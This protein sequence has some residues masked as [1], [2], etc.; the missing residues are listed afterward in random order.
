M[1]CSLCIARYLDRFSTALPI[2]HSLIRMITS[3]PSCIHI[4]CMLTYA[5]SRSRPPVH[6]AVYSAFRRRKRL[7]GRLV[8]QPVFPENTSVIGELSVEQNPA[9]TSLSTEIVESSRPVLEIAPWRLHKTAAASSP[10]RMAATA[11]CRAGNST[12]ATACPTPVRSS[13]FSP[14]MKSAKNWPLYPGNSIPLATS[15]TSW[16]NSSPRWRKIAFRAATPFP[17]P[18]SPNSCCTAF[19]PFAARSRTA[20]AMRA[21][22]KLCPLF[23]PTVQGPL[24]TNQRTMNTY[25]KTACNPCRMNTYETNDLKFPRMNTYRK[26]G[27]WGVLW[28]RSGRFR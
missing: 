11:D 27:G 18:I 6:C 12:L 23:S 20:S 7:W 1:C 2:F 16:E 13:S 21:G 25:K 10:T 9:E 24:T 3:K 19:P 26:T 28:L 17:L 5:M 22:R 8:S 14:P 15:T 4:Y